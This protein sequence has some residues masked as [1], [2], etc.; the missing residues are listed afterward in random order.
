MPQRALGQSGV[1]VSALGFGVSGPLG[2]PL[3]SAK[4]VAGLVRAAIDGGVSLFDTAPFYGAAD[5]RLGA[6]LTGIDRANV[7]I[8]SKGGT[9]RAG[10][11]VLKDFSERALRADLETSLRALRSTYLDVFLLHGPSQAQFTPETAR[12]LAR[13]KAEKLVRATG[14]CTRGADSAWFVGKDEI[15][16]IQ[17]PIEDLSIIEA[18]G[19]GFIAIEIMRNSANDVR[20]PRRLSDLWYLARGVLRRRAGVTADPKRALSDALSHP[21][22]SAALFT[23]TRLPHLERNIGSVLD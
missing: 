4:E 15:D 6:A 2:S 19:V 8:I 20:L 12:T 23:T 10:R 21:H 18:H 14:V 13:L 5:A 7:Q 3:V 9:R 16:V 11:T 1:L 22:I 17:A